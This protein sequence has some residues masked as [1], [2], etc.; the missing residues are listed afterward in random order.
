MKNLILNE[1]F[2]EKMWSVIFKI[3]GIGILYFVVWLILED[4]T[5][6]FGLACLVL[7]GGIVFVCG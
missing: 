4:P 2:I 1:H 7:I 3:L 6:I 5:I